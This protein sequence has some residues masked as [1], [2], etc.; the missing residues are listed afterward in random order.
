MYIAK[1]S[2]ASGT[3]LKVSD[4]LNKDVLIAVYSILF[5]LYLLTA[6]I[7]GVPLKVI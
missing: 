4:Y 1:I 3:I 6:V 7:F 5:A 2:H